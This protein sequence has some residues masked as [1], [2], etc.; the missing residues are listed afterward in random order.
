MKTKKSKFEVGLEEVKSRKEMGGEGSVGK[1]G[2]KVSWRECRGNRW[3]EGLAKWKSWALSITDW[4]PLTL[5]NHVLRNR[6]K[7]AFDIYTLIGNNLSFQQ[8]NK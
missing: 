7:D 3:G 8:E 2:V 6:I 4:M 1:N 5:K